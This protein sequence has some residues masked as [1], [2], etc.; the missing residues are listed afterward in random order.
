MMMMIVMVRD[1]L[2]IC[3]SIV[4]AS[5]RRGISYFTNYLA[6]TASIVSSSTRDALYWLLDLSGYNGGHTRNIYIINDS[7]EKVQ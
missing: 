2:F 4:R 1:I 6:D 7:H 5:M 3:K